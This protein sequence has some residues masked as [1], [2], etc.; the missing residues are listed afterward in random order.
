MT[1][2]DTMERGRERRAADGPEE[3]RERRPATG[4]CTNCARV[5]SCAYRLRGDGPVLHCEEFSI[6]R[7]PSG[8]SAAHREAPRP[9]SS[10]VGGL[11][12]TCRHFSSCT[13]RRPG[14]LVWECEEFS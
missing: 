14:E 13:L 5:S 7:M 10:A 11:C 6:P 2:L 1:V 8:L 12:A 3:A 4:L 9:P